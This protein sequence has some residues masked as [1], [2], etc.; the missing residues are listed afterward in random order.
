MPFRG[1]LQL[2]A[3]ALLRALVLL[4]ALGFALTIAPN[5]AEADR[6][7]RVRSGDTLS[8][9]A[10]RFRISVSELR[11]ANRMRGD[12]LREGQTLRIPSRGS[13]RARARAARR[14]G[15]HLVRRGD[16]LSEIAARYRV[17]IRAL[18]RANRIRGENIRVGQRLRI[19]GR[20]RE[21]PLSRVQPR[22]LR[23]D[24]EAAAPRAEQLGLGT[25]RVA[26]TLLKDPP[27]PA[28]VEA[29]AAAPEQIPAHAYGVG[30][31]ITERE[32][33]EIDAESGVDDGVGI[34]ESADEEL[35]GHDHDDDDHPDPAAG[36]EDE[37][38]DAEESPEPP[39]GP[40]TLALPL[41]E[42]HYMRGWGSGAGGYHLA[43]DMYS[44]PRTPVHAAER[45]VVAYASHGVRGYG[46][47]VIVVHPSGLVTAYAHLHE[48]LVVP[49]E[50]VA[51]GQVVGLLGNTGL[52]RG[53][54]LH[55]MLVHDGEHC[56]PLPL[57]RPR[58]RL[59]NGRLVET[60]P[61]AWTGEE[62]EAVR[63]L[64]RSARQHPGQRRRRRR[65]RR[66]R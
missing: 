10:R 35:E 44:P 6:R 14:A 52:S 19:P 48:A 17:P 45:G 42:G 41:P 50:L 47:F 21:N 11:R 30:T 49:G 34:D 9:I 57:F 43:I 7:Y 38:E 60:T 40:G 23:P 26:Q 18:R 39:A 32:V 20:R 2:L 54:H 24:Q 36:G 27:E 37:G 3:R 66:R 16:T 33:E 22:P 15:Y 62:P 1:R 4:V 51:R 13:R 64:P 25:E 12:R 58:L 61:A 59:R 55:F 8:E 65:A 29:A 46:R 31:P 53:P 5:A 56:D 63:C 28:W